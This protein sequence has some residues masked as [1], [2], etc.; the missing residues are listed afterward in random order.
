MKVLRHFNDTLGTSAKVNPEVHEQSQ[1]EPYCHIYKE[2]KKGVYS[3]N[4]FNSSAAP[5]SCPL[6]VTIPE[7]SVD[8]SH[9]Q[10][11]SNGTVELERGGRREPVLL[12]RLLCNS[13]NLAVL[14]ACLCHTQ[15][16]L[17]TTPSAPVS[18]SGCALVP[19]VLAQPAQA[20]G[21]RE[22]VPHVT[23]GEAT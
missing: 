10:M 23:K 13:Q 19:A 15:T 12:Y 17:V 20:E 22:E 21:D 6:R 11:N 7:V 18:I 9:F 1:P 3:Q 5:K 14:P 4:F 2:V 16:H 8:F